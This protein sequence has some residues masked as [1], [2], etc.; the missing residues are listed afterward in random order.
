MSWPPPEGVGPPMPPIAETSKE[1]RT[2]ED[3]SSNPHPRV[4]F[5]CWRH[6]FL[7]QSKTK[8]RRTL[9]GKRP[10]HSETGLHLAQ[11]ACD[12]L[13]LQGRAKY[14]SE[15]EPLMRNPIPIFHPFTGRTNR[16]R[17]CPR[18][19]AR[20]DGRDP[21]RS[22]ME[23]GLCPLQTP[24]WRLADVTLIKPNKKRKEFVDEGVSIFLRHSI[25]ATLNQ[26]I[27]FLRLTSR[28]S[29]LV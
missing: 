27:C 15:A 11:P 16:I 28:S 2:L 7:R 1:E 20:E 8:D 6:D 13:H 29:V 22:R 26:W 10:V 23:Q 24:V 12:G 9:R 19:R 14:N 18:R 17:A 21:R 4:R 3:I 25:I 5:Y